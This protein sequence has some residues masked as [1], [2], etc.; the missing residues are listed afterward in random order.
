MSIWLTHAD[1]SGLIKLTRGPEN[2]YGS[3]RWSPDGRW[4]AFDARNTAGKWSIQMVEPGG[5]QARRV[6][7]ELFNAHVPNWSRDG[8]W[9][10]FTSEQTGRSEIWRARAQ[11]GSAEQ[12]TKDGG[13]V[14]REGPDGKTLYYTKRI[15]VY[16]DLPL[17]ARPLAGG[18][19]KQVLAAVRYRAFEVFDDGIYY[20]TGGGLAGNEIRFYDFATGGSLVVASIEG[21]LHLG[22]SVSPNRNTF[23]F[24]KI[25]S[26][27]SDLMLIENFR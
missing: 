1:G 11:G 26:A 19:E 24:S 21:Q 3:P 16:E 22:F 25:V 4:I 27:G 20:I 8:K 2:F 7:S 18:E 17:Y 15:D 9:I 13:Y 5:G 6:V 12:I 14:A 23:L 10:Y